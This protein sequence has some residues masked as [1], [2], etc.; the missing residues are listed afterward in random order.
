MSDFEIEGESNSDFE[1]S[2]VDDQ[3][4]SSRAAAEPTFK[5]P[6]KTYSNLFGAG[7]DEGQAWILKAKFA[8]TQ[9]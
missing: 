8:K 2:W 5:Q 3:P 1:V 7:H 6:T 9:V 4:K